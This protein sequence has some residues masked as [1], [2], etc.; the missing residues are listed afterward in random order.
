MPELL[1]VLKVLLEANFE[2]EAACNSLT[3]RTPMAAD[4]DYLMCIDYR[5]VKERTVKDAYPVGSMDAILDQL[6]GANYI[7]K[8]DLKNA[9]LQVPMAPVSKKYT[10]FP[11]PGTG[12]YHFESSSAT[13]LRICTISS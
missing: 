11:V 8:I 4:V 6:G 3:H 2:L 12:L 9:Y 5:T 7:S 10:A 1:T 13:C